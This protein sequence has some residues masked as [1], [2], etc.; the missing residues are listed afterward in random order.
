MG[1]QNKEKASHNK[2]CEAFGMQWILSDIQK[3]N[4]ENTGYLFQGSYGIL[5]DYTSIQTQEAGHGKA[6]SFRGL[7]KF[8]IAEGD[9]HG[10]H[11]IADYGNGIQRTDQNGHMDPAQ[12]TEEDNFK[13]ICQEHGD[14]HGDENT[15]GNDIIADTD[16][17]TKTGNTPESGSSGKSPDLLMGGYHDGTGTDETDTGNNLGCVF[18][19]ILSYIYQF[20]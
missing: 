6:L 14:Q 5:V 3:F 8:Q 10:L 4:V 19:L 9:I 16:I 12:M 2:L 18:S 7:G 15:N 13:L 17:N 20:I 11:F 1:R